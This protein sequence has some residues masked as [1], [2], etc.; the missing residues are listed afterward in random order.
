MCLNNPKL[1]IYSIGNYKNHPHLISSNIYLKAQFQNIRFKTPPYNRD[2]LL[3]QIKT[4]AS[5]SEINSIIR[6]NQAIEIE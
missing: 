4:K 1:T 6:E 2:N 3:G 5:Q